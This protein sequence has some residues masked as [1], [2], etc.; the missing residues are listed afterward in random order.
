MVEQKEAFERLLQ[1][2]L[3]DRS[4]NL[5]RLLS[6]VCRK[7]FEGSADELKEY[8]I[9]TEAL[10]RPADFDQKR[11][12]IVRV[13]IHRLRKRLLQYYETAGKDE[14]LRIV[15]P[16]GKYVPLF[17]PALGAREVVVA[18]ALPQ[19]TTTSLD[20]PGAETAL[21]T[22]AD[23]RGATIPA[24]PQPPPTIPAGPS[25]VSPN[26][27]T[28]AVLVAGALLLGVG[29]VWSRAKSSPDEK[30]VASEQ[31]VASAAVPAFDSAGEIRILA[32]RDKDYTDQLGYR[33][34]ADRYFTG[35]NVNKTPH[36]SV[37]RSSDPA[38]F[39][40]QREGEF[41][42]DIPL[43]PGHYELRLYFGETVFGEGNPAGGAESTRLFDVI[44]NGTRVLDLFDVLADAPG[45]RVADIRVFK[46]IQPA[47]DGKLHL[48]FRPNMHNEPFVNAIEVRRTTPGRI[49]PIRMV[50]QALP[51]R[52]SLGRTWEPDYLASG[53]NVVKRHRPAVDT[54][55][56]EIYRGERFG[57]FQ[58]AIPVAPDGTYKLSLFFHEAWFGPGNNGGGGEG[59][60]AFDVYVNHNALLA[61]FDLFR[62][63][64]TARRALVKTFHGLKPNARGKLL[65]SLEPTRNYA[66]I[67]A[68]EVE[69]ESPATRP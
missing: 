17:V 56:P 14:P 62:A 53:G 50:A 7:H 44:A 51:I 52:D 31:S 34:S 12:S 23:T 3:L 65:I 57:N 15:I 59:T 25:R 1:S 26:R 4:Q 55:T 49:R 22:V 24:T 18:E 32:G 6:Y 60:R 8:T 29:Y 16:E 61:N 28:T 5:K 67:N 48:S 11:D 42:Y 45:A 41:Q 20:A 2:G 64:G 19:L 10:G 30:P 37:E 27:M 40:G 54:E 66:C 63:A 9:A 47:A 21:V 33:W 13:E 43:D 46:G 69:D 68:L 58:Y 39:T 35:G 36:P 38:L